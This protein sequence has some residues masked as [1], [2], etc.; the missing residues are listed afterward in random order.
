M[1]QYMTTTTKPPYAN[2][3]A[4]VNGWFA[5]ARS[6]FDHPIVGAGSLGKYSRMEAWLWMINN[7]ARRPTKGF[8]GVLEIEL[9][10]G[11]L[12]A[13][14]R[15]LARCW[16]WSPDAV[17]HFLER[18]EST[19]SI[20]QSKRTQST[21]AA[22]VVFLVY[23]ADHQLTDEENARREHAQ[24]AQRPTSID[25][26]KDTTSPNGEITPS[27]IEALEAFNSYNT[28]AQKLGL[29][30]AATF[31]P[32]RKARIKARLKE[33]GGI[34]AWQKALANLQL[35]PFLKGL[36]DRG[37]KAS[38]EWLVQA[39]SFAKLVDGVYGDG[40]PRKLG[41]VLKTVRDTSE[42]F[43]QLKART[44]WKPPEEHT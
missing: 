7:A 29:P 11:E 37:W 16:G 25:K 24:R 43:E 32:S 3:S 1:E 14:L 42:T 44:G 17:R 26:D 39:S 4:R 19:H 10:P 15:Y 8:D 20:R 5:V 40:K 34:T 41:A 23:W 31:T 35:S 27:D 28:L 6:I 12:I 21:H 18:L 30:Q 2:R 9:Q 36:N 22:N 33:H 38:L 13:P